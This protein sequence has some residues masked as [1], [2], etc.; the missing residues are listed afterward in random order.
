MRQ[1]ASRRPGVVQVFPQVVRVF[2]SDEFKL[3]LQHRQGRAQLVASIRHHL[4]L[5]RG[6][7][8]QVRDQTVQRLCQRA[9]LVARRTDGKEILRTGSDDAFR[10]VP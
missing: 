5:A 2:C 9:D 3:G 1:A 7:A 6:R 10:A 8:P 4:T